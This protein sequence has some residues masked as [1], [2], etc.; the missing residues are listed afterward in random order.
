MK[1]GGHV[2][3]LL[4]PTSPEELRLA[5]LAAREY[6][7]PVRVLGG[8]ANLLIADG[9]LPGVVLATDRLDRLFRP[10]T[11]DEEDPM[12]ASVEGIAKVAPVERE[13]DPRLVSWCG[14]SLPGIVRAAQELGWTGLEGL[15]GVPG[16]LGGGVAMNAGGRWGDLWD[17][18][19]TVRVLE[20]SGE[21]RDLQRAECHPDYRNGNLGE[22]IVLGAVLRLE[23]ENSLVIKDRMRQFLLEKKAAQPVT[24]SSSGCIFKNPDRELAGGRSAGQLIDELGL[25]GLASGAAEVSRLHGNFIINTGGARAVDVLALIAEVIA[26]VE[27][28]TGIRLEREVRVWSAK[29]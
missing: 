3:W 12:D 5:W 17:V 11:F 1:V 25:K 23:A 2:E 14:T 18:I 16:Q 19:E 13:R 28:E 9:T 29:E 10:G 20:P 22:S 21:V 27:G 4:E 7:G 8:G 26:R 6:G 24:E 15:V